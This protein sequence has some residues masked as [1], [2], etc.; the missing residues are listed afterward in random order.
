MADSQ[1]MHAAYTHTSC[2]M[3]IPCMQARG[4]S[5]FPYAVIIEWHVLSGCL[6]RQGL[7]SDCDSQLVD[8]QQ[9]LVYAGVALFMK[10]QSV[11]LKIWS[12]PGSA[13]RELRSLLAVF[14]FGWPPEEPMGRQPDAAPADNADA[15]GAGFFLASGGQP[16]AG[17]PDASEPQELP[18][19]AEMQQQEPVQVRSS[20][21][22][23][24]SCP[25]HTRLQQQHNVNSK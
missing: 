15:G 19:I 1:N 18:D 5:M 14:F 2:K 25:Q 4:D 9:R 12:L 3:P 13:M 8:C 6:A 24:E 17:H 11:V 7:T 10:A 21:G 23:A 16:A 22:T 20:C